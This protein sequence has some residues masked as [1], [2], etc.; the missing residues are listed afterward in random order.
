[1][2]VLTRR[3]AL[4]LLLLAFPALPG[5]AAP[6]ASARPGASPAEAEEYALKAAFLFN[7]TKFVDW[8]ADAFAEEKGPFNL[9]V[10]GE[11]PFA[12]GLDAVVANETWNGRPIV[13]RKGVKGAEI[14]GCQMLFI[15]RAEHERQAEV[16]AG[17]RGAS[18][19]SV[20]EDDQFLAQGGLINFFLEAKRV[21]FAVDLKSV[22]ESRLTISSKLLRLAK[23]AGEVPR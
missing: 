2:A 23:V 20:G 10:L 18:V 1:L 4:G 12:G 15:P 14:R 19:L 7:F 6:R 22:G 17:L 5:L 9:C 8:P 3:A 21:R 16:L 11:D 13:V